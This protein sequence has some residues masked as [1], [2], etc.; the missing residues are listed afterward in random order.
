MRGEGVGSAVNFCISV[1][2]G[3]SQVLQ[4]EEVGTVVNFWISYVILRQVFRTMSVP[5]H[6]KLAREPIHTT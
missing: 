4:G 2:N 6:A 1:P 3:E 5:E